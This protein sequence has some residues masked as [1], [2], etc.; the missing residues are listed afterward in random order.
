MPVDPPAFPVRLGN[1]PVYAMLVQFP[2]VC[3][4][5]TL[6][7]D[8]AYWRTNLY[9]W[10][11]FSV[12]LLAAGCLMAGLTGIVGLVC[13][14]KDRRVRSWSLAWPHALTSLLAALLSVVNAFV[15]SRDGYTAVVPT[16]LTLSLIVVVLMLVAAWMGNRHEGRHTLTGVTA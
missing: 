3:F 13:F 5:G 15:H 1:L 7:T 12:W 14:A 6:V 4:A 10:E 16:G 11:T 2:V 9:I 8:L